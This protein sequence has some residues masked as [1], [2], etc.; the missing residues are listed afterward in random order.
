MV[1]DEDG[2]DKDDVI[3]SSNDSSFSCKFG[4]HG[5]SLELL[6]LRPINQSLWRW[7]QPPVIF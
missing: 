1:D 7:S 5:K 2:D 3:F 6:K 4:S